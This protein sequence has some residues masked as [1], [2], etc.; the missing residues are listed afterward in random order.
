MGKRRNEEIQALR[1]GVELGMALIDTA[2]MYGN[3]DLVGKVVRSCRD[4][5]FW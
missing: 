1:R 3:E 2:E 4:D 5:V